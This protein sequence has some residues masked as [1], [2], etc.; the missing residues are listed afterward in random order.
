MDSRYDA[1][2]S[3]ASLR[4][5]IISPGAT[6]HKKAQEALL[7]AKKPRTESSLGLEEQKD[8]KVKAFDLLDALSRSGA[9]PLQHAE[10]HVVVCATQAFDDTV[11]DTVVAMNVNP[12]ERAERSALI[13]AAAVHG[14]PS[15]SAS[16]YSSLV[17]QESVARVSGLSPM[18]F[19]ETQVDDN[20]L[21]TTTG[22]AS[23]PTSSAD[24]DDLLG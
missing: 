15:R 2:D 17:K 5:T 7:A 11:V 21:A 16:G 9:L 6:W 23:N 8:E 19:G 4:P 14:L 24:Q 13:M 3:S 10:L 1:L 12:I 18:L 22:H 20:T